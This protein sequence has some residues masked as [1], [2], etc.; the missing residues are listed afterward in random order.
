MVDALKSCKRNM[1]DLGGKNHFPKHEICEE[2]DRAV[3]LKHHSF[4]EN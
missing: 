1:K 4:L 3:L 2:K